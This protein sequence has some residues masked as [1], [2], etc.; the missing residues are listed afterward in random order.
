MSKIMINIGN[1]LV[2]EDEPVLI[3]A[4]AGVN[5]NGSMDMALRMV[6]EAVQ[7]GA[8]CIK[9][10]TF[11]TDNIETKHSLKPSYF[12]GRDS[13]LDKLAYLK[14]VE[15]NKEEFKKI[16]DYC[17]SKNIMFLSTV[18][19]TSGLELLLSIGVLAIKVGSSDTVN[20]PLLKEIG[21]TGLPLI[22]S[23][24]I[25]TLKDVDIAV[26][27]LSD[28]GCRQMAILQ[29]TSEYPCSAE[30][31]NLN[32]I[33]TMRKRYDCPI[34]FSDHSKGNY[35]AVA[36]IAL[37]AKIIER[38]FTLDRSLPGVDHAASSTPQEMKE[39]VKLIRTT[40]K[41]LG[42][43]EKIIQP[44]EREH[45][46]TMRKSVVAAS[47]FPKGTV[48]TYDKIK[49]KRPGTGISPLEIDRVITKRLKI[50]VKEDDIIKWDMLE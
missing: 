3:I 24:G 22:L 17:D 11:E 43:G 27:S 46:I 32:V 8:D 35:V 31:L 9:F 16:K 28:F 2:G 40:E 42:N 26:K 7:F 4:E 13:G 10:Q 34:G 33:K 25:S 39:L 48:I 50:E 20:L 23:T 44:H 36:A 6:D 29:C 18:S 38:H 15:F 37:G 1:R 19:D 41:A 21:K 5:H 47:D 30:E 14:S 49:V 45:L 12:N